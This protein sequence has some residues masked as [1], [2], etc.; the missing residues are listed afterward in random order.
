[1]SISSTT[2]VRLPLELKSRVARLAAASG[3]STH[4]FIVEAVAERALT[5]EARADFERVAQERWQHYQ[6]TGLSVSMDDMLQYARD[7]AAGKEAPR[8]EARKLAKTQK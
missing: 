2:T 7:L 5:E 6:R 4:S 3:V 1:M 8:P